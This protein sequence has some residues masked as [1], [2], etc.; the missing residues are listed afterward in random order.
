MTESSKVTHPSQPDGRLDHG[1]VVTAADLMPTAREDVALLHQR[2]AL[3]AETR[4]GESDAEASDMHLL[5][6]RLEGD[7]NLAVPY[8]NLVEVLPPQRATRVPGSPPSVLGVVNFSGTILTVMD[9]GQVLQLPEQTRDGE[10]VIVVGSSGTSVAFP[11][12][13]LVGAMD[14]R[15]GSIIAAPHSPASERGYLLGV[16]DN[17]IGVLDVARILG[18]ER[19]LVDQ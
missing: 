19:L 15:S 9:L 12:R 5:H 10:A 18:D 8:Q 4:R 14:A 2:A 7:T 3:L 1:A 11:V 6:I 17:G 16:V 13:E